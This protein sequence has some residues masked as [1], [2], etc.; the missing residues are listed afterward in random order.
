ML[1]VSCISDYK[2]NSINFAG[3]I[4]NFKSI[5]LSQLVDE[6]QYI[7]LESNSEIILGYVTGIDMDSN[8]ILISDNNKCLLYDLNGDFISKI[9][10]RGKGPGEFQYHGNP[11]L[12]NKYIFI[13]DSRR[14]LV[15]NKSGDF[16]KSILSPVRFNNNPFNSSWM[17]LTDT[18][19]ISHIRNKKGNEKNKALIFGVHSDTLSLFKNYD[20]FERNKSSYSGTDDNI[21]QFYFYNGVLSFKEYFNDTIFRIKNY[22]KMTPA[23]NIYLGKYKFPSSM[24]GLDPIE[25]FNKINDHL[26]IRNIYELDNYIFFNF[27]FVNNYPLKST[28]EHIVL[29]EVQKGPAPIIGMYDKNSKEVFF[30]DSS[31]NDDKE[32]PN[33]IENDIDGGMNFFPNYCIDGSTLLMIISVYKLKA[34][35][36]SAVFKNTKPKYP[37]KKNELE[38]LANSL[39]ENDNPVLM[40]VKLK[41]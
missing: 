24:R 39:N 40:L 9:G 30:I 20:K 5:K 12:G 35:I 15:F 36:N 25:Y 18:A 26:M 10:Q 22:R 31:C 3:N 33:G 28:M 4:N 37:E 11:I 29:G 21:A 27:R 14:L 34:Y 8:N 2:Q 38:K 19:F 7:T 6:I 16:I 23:Y 17:P 1:F 41:E 32:N 13:P